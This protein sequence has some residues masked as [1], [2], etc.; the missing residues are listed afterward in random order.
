[1]ELSAFFDPINSEWLTDEAAF[2]TFGHA[3]MGHLDEFPN[4]K[5]ADIIIFG[6]LGL[7]PKDDEDYMAN[8]I[9][10]QLYVLSLPDESMMVADLGNLA[11]EEADEEYQDLIIQILDYLASHEKL[12]ILLANKQEISLAQILALEDQY[13]GLQY[14]HID[15]RLDVAA[16]EEMF[17]SSNYNYHLLNHHNDLL[18]DFINLGYQRYLVSQQ[19]L[20]ELKSRNYQAIRYGLLHNQIEE[21]EPFLRM[22]DVI[23]FD[24]SAIRH[25]DMPGN[26]RPSPGGFNAM[27]ACRMARYAG[28]AYQVK[29]I[30][31]SEFKPEEDL[32]DQGSLMT[33]MLIWYFID[34]W[35]N[36]W[37]DKPDEQ[38]SNLRKY[39]VQLRATI[40]QIHFFQHL[41]SGRWWMEV[42]YQEDLGQ[43]WGRSLLIPCSERDYQLAREDDI[44]ERWWLTYNKLK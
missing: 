15:G 4:W 37:Q 18:F 42:P 31:F 41:H 21:S 1:M 17:S 40:E 14:V 38:R 13:E 8:S 29:S 30:S 12:V 5:N 25:A 26:H 28:L 44:P 16:D 20:L 36:K 27:E 24:L 35:Y 11:Y 33:A 19:E 39:D 23:S 43:T 6:C 34:G 2:G 3:V 7:H 10:E 32:H 9:R 22:A